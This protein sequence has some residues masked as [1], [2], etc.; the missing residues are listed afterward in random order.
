MVHATPL[1]DSCSLYRNKHFGQLYPL[2]GI[3]SLVAG[4]AAFLL[5]PFRLLQRSSLRLEDC[6]LILKSREEE[7]PIALVTGA[8]TGIGFETAASLVER[9]YDVILG[10]RSRDKGESAVSLINER[11]NNRPSKASSCGNAI[12]LHPLDLS[13]LESVR[14]FAEMFA[15]KY[16]CL[17]I[18]VNNA[19]INST[20]KSIDGLDLCFQTNFVGHYLLTRIL[21][22]LLLKAKNFTRTSSGEIKEQSGRIVNL[23]SVT[24]HF[25]RADEER[26]HGLQR[27][28]NQGT[29]MGCNTNGTHDAEW[30]RGCATPGTSNNTYKESKLAAIIFTNEL[31]RR[32]GGDGLRAVAVSPGAVNSDIWRTMPKISLGN[33]IRHLYLT[34]KQGSITSVVAAVGNLPSGAVYLQPYWLPQSNAISV[35]EGQTPSFSRWYKCPF[36][37]FEMMGPYIGYAVT[38]PRLPADGNASSVALWDVCEVLAAYNK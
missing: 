8:N 13:S 34:S 10:C 27:D 17:N 6:F 21:L 14:T 19:G 5:K 22:P 30:W 26:D 3:Y 15:Q 2:V 35:M 18:L 16:S 4:V 7:K 1:Q 20:G 29:G 31:N 9:G 33:A 36:P 25:A 37:V 12:F 38:D 32:F 28:S 24:H 23:S 11:I